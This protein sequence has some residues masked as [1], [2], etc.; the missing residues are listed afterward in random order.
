M[1]SEAG[2]MLILKFSCSPYYIF[3]SLLYFS[4]RYVTI[5]TLVAVTL[6]KPGEILLKMYKER[7]LCSFMEQTY[8]MP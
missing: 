4:R 2:S 6:H 1:G 3:P 5:G 8:Y 7:K